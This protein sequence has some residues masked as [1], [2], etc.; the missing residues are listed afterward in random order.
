MQAFDQGGGWIHYDVDPLGQVWRQVTPRQR[1]AGTATLQSFDALGRL[2]DRYEPDL[3]SHWVFDTAAKGVG[4]LAESYTGPASAKDYRQL[5]AYDAYGRPASTTTWLDTSYVATNE[6]DAWGRLSATS[7]QRGSDAA[8]RYIRHYNGT[9]YLESIERNGISL[10]RVSG[11][12][13]ANRVTQSLLGSG[14][15]D[16]RIFSATTGRLGSA[17]LT[18]ADGTARLQEAYQ[19]DVLG[20]VS[21][22][23][24]YWDAG[25]FAETFGYDALNRLVSAQVAG[26]AE[27]V[28]AF[29]AIGNL[30]SKTGV[31]NG[32][33]T[34]PTPG[35]GAVGPHAVSSI[36]G[37]GSFSYDA[38]GNLI[39]GGGRTLSWTSANYPRRITK[40]DSWI[41]FAYGPEHQRSKQTKSDGTIVYY[42]GAMEVENRSGALTVKTYW[43][44][45]LGVE[46]DRPGAATQLNWT[47]TDR[48]GSVVALS[49]EDGTLREK[50]AYDAWGKRRALDGS[51][52]PDSLDGVTDDRG[53]TGHEMLDSVDLVHMNGRVYDPLTARFVSADPYIQSPEDSQSYNRYSYV[54]NN[55]TNLTDPTGFESEGEIEKVE[56]VGRRGGN[57]SNVAQTIGAGM[58]AAALVGRVLVT[59]AGRTALTVLQWGCKTPISCAV[60]GLGVGAFI[61]YEVYLIASA[62]QQADGEEKKSGDGEALKGADSG[63]GSSASPPPDDD[64]TKRV[65][66]PK[67]HPN[68]ISPEPENAEELFQNS[69]KDKNGV[70]WVKDADG[71][72]HRFSKSSNGELHWNGSTGGVD[73]IKEQNVPVEIR[74]AFGK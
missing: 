23:S 50:L 25:G 35:S 63:A 26:Q 58:A 9:G 17:A 8:K 54:W 12:D 38:D 46:I 18:T 44:S 16:S 64:K 68:S 34:Y 31:G 62:S 61:G 1:A 37:V 11:Q 74:R 57:A 41:E 29:D 30:T 10:W 45:G 69:I 72:I 28:F 32:G 36:A 4:R 13:A 70:R 52:T 67:H 49:A 15:T 43:P 6:Y 71:T 19:Y 40:G 21:S 47:H 59:P 48:L 33:Y 20:N 53:F 2:T 27:Q 66:N 60:V 55:P 42:A 73:P 24:Q 39:S 7:E 56:V 65:T 14:L 51:A 5:S 3:E 22:R